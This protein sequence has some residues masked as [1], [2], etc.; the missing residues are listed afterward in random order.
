VNPRIGSGMQQAR[1][2]MEEQAVEGVR[3]PEDGTRTGAGSPRPEGQ[4]RESPRKGGSK[5]GKPGVDSRAH[6]DGGANLWTT[7]REEPDR[8]VGWQGPGRAGKD[9]AKVRGACTSTIK[10]RRAARS[11]VLE[12]QRRAS[13]ARPRRT[14]VNRHGTAASIGSSPRG[15]HPVRVGRARIASGRSRAAWMWR[16]SLRRTPTP[17]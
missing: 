1:T 13:V 17:W 5:T 9:G 4:P 3:N 8:E 6:V 14:A 15:S 11:K 2:A 16:R 7:P 12:G 10:C